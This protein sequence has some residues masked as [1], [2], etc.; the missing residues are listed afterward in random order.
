[1]GVP[2]AVSFGGD[3][4][5]GRGGGGVRLIGR[6]VGDSEDDLSLGSGV[7]TDA[8]EAGFSMGFGVVGADGK[9]VGE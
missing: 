9:L 8:V 7:G 2:C 1:M 4:V 5:D 3:R 6:Y